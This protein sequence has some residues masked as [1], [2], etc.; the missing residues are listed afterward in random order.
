MLSLLAVASALI[1]PARAGAVPVRAA[2][3]PMPD[4]AANDNTAAG[5]DLRHGTLTLALVARR[6]RWYPDGPGTLGL[7]VDAFGEAGRPLRIPGPLVRVPLGTRVV[8]SVRN[9]LPADLTVRGLA[10]PGDAALRLLRVPRGATRRTAFVLDRPGTFGY[11]GSEHGE[12]LDNRIF[13]DA[14]LTGAIV[15]E[16]PRAPRVDHIFVLSLYDAVKSPDG[17]PNFLYFLETINGRSFPATESLTYERGQHVRWAVYNGSAMTHPMHL[18]GFY[19][20]LPG[21][22]AYD[23]VTH[24]FHPGEGN[25]LAWTADRAGNWMFHCHITDHT[26]RH[27]PLRDMLTHRAAPGYGVVQRFHLPGRSMSGMVIAVSVLPRAGDRAPVAAASPRRLTLAIDG[28]DQAKE[29]YRGLWKGT[30][31]L[32]DGATTTPSTGNL[33]P[34]IVL[35]RNQPVAIAV[36]NRTNEPTSMHWHGIELADSY[37]DGAAGMGP[38]RMG[39]MSG[40]EMAAL[41]PSPAIAPGETF[42]A[43]FAPPDAGTFMYHSHLDDGWQLGAGLDGPLIVLP[44]GQKFDAATD[45]IVMISESYEKAGSPFVA[46]GGSLT[47]APITMTAGVPQRLRFAVMSLGG[48]NL[49]ASLA[50]GSRVVQWTPIAKDGRDLPGRL[51]RAAPATQAL[52][53]GETRDFRFTPASPGKLTLTVYDNDN[54]GMAVATVPVIIDAAR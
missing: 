5:G 30:L 31:Q 43:R 21:Q 40:A 51:Q 48:Q 26:S 39:G 42:V 35:A 24:A 46:V 15:V 22:D 14:L 3:P 47:P 19:F 4:I 2:T 50:D 9:E 6:G 28:A 34:P 1:F 25:E 23:Q 18:H 8:V 41:R 20:R 17:S 38:M 7:P 27:A 44:A 13:D 29:P 45:H 33:G 11:D 53:I 49:V 36:V 54:N 10:A 52:T 16:R 32:I 12:S 37:Y